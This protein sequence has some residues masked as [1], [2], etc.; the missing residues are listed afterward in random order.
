MSTERVDAAKAEVNKLLDVSV[1]K[2]VQYP[3]WLA[4]VVMVRK[5]NGNGE[6]VW[7]SQTSA[8]AVQNTHIHYQELTS[9]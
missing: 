9:Y 6:C 1:I 3:E 7:I 2:P 5:K 4:N 8:S